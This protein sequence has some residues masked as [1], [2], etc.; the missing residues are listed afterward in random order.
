MTQEIGDVDLEAARRK[1]REER[2]K[3]LVR[4]RA[5]KL[6]VTTHTQFL[7]DPYT[8]FV[9]REPVT[10]DVDAVVVGAGFGG[11]MAAAHLRKIGLNRVRLIEKAGDVGGVWY[12][13]RYPAAQC[14]VESYVYLPFLEELQYIPQHRYSFAPEIFAYTKRLAEH[15]GLYDHALFQTQVDGLEWDEDAA[16]WIVRTDRGDEFRARYVVSTHGSFASPRLPLIPG[17]DD[18]RG[19]VFH[20]ARWDYEYTG[21]DSRS[22]LD[23]LGDKRVGV[24]G[25]GASAIQIVAPLGASAEHLYVFQ[26]TPSTV[27]ERNNSETDV[28]WMTSLEPGWQKRRRENFTLITNG[29]PVSEDLV[30]DAWTVFYKAMLGNVFDDLS[31]E[32]RALKREELDLEHMESIRARVS[33]IVTDPEV[34]ERLKPYYRYQCKRPTFHDEYLSTFNRPNVTLV[35]TEGRGI[36][37]ITEHGVVAGGVEYELDCIILAT[38]FDQDSSYTDRIGFD[39]V[40]RD[41]QRLS[42]KWADGPETF[43]GVMT[44]GFPNFFMLPTTGYQGTAGVNFVHTLEETGI[45]IAAVI[46]ELEGRAVVGDPSREAEEAYVELVAGGS[47]L[48]LLGSGKF[49]EDCTPGRWNNEGHPQERP[50]KIVNFPGTSTKYFALLE[51]WRAAGDLEG[52]V[53][54][55]AAVD[56]RV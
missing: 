37:R 12:W 5:A 7:D 50:K 54:T 33:S 14:D 26:R 15:F 29:E 16:R 24:I 39:L 25:T 18:F 53:L 56:E 32:E 13:N 10:D 41:G 1:Y 46:A 23:K 28:E 30:G 47:G 52:L 2:D 11:L 42:Q 44:S 4:D 34:A 17:I 49:L 48:A 45:H 19:K 9:P 55:P 22:K 20:T 6:D 31:P 36:E 3:R 35:D 8:A 38:G 51:Q 27:A 40:G 43:H 21:G